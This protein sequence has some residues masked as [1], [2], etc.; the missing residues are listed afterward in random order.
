MN[1]RIRIAAL[2][3]LLLAGLLIGQHRRWISPSASR[4][5]APQ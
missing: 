3:G 1:T 2:A 5:Y 4:C